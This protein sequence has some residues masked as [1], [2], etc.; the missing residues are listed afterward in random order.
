[1][2]TKSKAPRSA[3]TYRGFRRNDARQLVKSVR[4]RGG[5]IT[6]ADAWEIAQTKGKRRGPTPNVDT[7]SHLVKGKAY[8]FSSERQHIRSARQTEGRANG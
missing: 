3:D 6:F 4:R 7:R 5:K 1:M 2:N 8:A